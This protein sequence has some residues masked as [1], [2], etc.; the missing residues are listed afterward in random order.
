MCKDLSPETA[1]YY[2]N[3]L[4]NARTL[5]ADSPADYQEILFALE[6]LGSYLTE[7][8]GTLKEFESCVK[9]LVKQHHP[10]RGFPLRGYPLPDYHISFGRL[11]DIVLQ[12][13]NSALHQGAVVRNLPS[14]CARLSIILEDTMVNI[15]R[16]EKGQSVQVKDYMVDTP[17]TTQLWHPVSFIRQIMLESS[18]TYIPYFTSIP[19]FGM[20]CRTEMFPSSCGAMAEIAAR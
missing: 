11:Y 8:E 16:K 13:R 19:V 5:T 18:F 20:P 3:S 7:K 2:R 10:L 1:I 9:R 17:V 6:R 4:R 12:G 14:R 15:V